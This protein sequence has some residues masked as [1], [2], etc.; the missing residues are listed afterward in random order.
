MQIMV[1]WSP[2]AFCGYLGS[3]VHHS[4]QD[5]VVSAARHQSFIAAHL[6]GGLLALCVLSFYLWLTGRPTLLGAVAFLW[7]LSPIGI[8]VFLSRSGRFGAAYLISAAN[9]AGL[10]TFSVWLTGG[11]ASF[12]I[13]WMVVVPLEAVLSTDR[14]VVAWAAALASLGLIALA[15]AGAGGLVPPAALPLPVSANLLG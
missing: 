4:V 9:F 2:R 6:L 12:L 11:I 8:T 7:F 14:R 15:A 3:L 13:P 5:D 10:I 1:S